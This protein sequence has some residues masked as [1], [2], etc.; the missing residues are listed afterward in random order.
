[1]TNQPEP[2]SAE[3]AILQVLWR[4]QP[5][6]VRLIHNT[7]IKTRKVGYTTTLKQIQRLEEKGVVKRVDTIGK[8]YRYRTVKSDTKIRRGVF[9]RLLKN[10]FSGSISSLVTFALGQND[11][12]LAELKEIKKLIKSMNDK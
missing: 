6:T 1:M 2:T 4:S 3:L 8:A 10:A 9:D 7:I 12:T 5:C 11:L